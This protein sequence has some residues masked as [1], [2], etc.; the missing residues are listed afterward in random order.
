MILTQ[1]SF[2]GGVWRGVLSDT[3]GTPA[4][5]AHLGGRALAAPRVTEEAGQVVV[6]VPVPSEA[7][8]DGVQA[9][10]IEA[11]GQVLATFAI[12]AG[13]VLQ[14]DLRAEVALLRAELAMLKTAFRRHCQETDA[15]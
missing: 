4:L 3:P 10:T 7:I 11:E 14:D 8:G 13:D 5:T 1:T 15:G 9:I 12:A 6:E 2:S